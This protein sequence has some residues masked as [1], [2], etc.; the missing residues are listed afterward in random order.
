MVSRRP[1]LLAE[2]GHA[3]RAACRRP[4]P[5]C[6]SRPHEPS[7]R[8]G[9]SRPRSRPRRRK[10]LAGWAETSRIPDVSHA[11][12]ID[13]ALPCHVRRSGVGVAG[14]CCVGELGLGGGRSRTPRGW[15]WLGLGLTL[16][17]RAHT[18]ARVGVCGVAVPDPLPVAWSAGP[19]RGRR[20]RRRRSR[21]RVSSPLRERLRRRRRGRCRR[22]RSPP[23]RGR[24][25]SPRR[26]ARRDGA[27]D[28][29]SG[30]EVI[31]PARGTACGVYGSGMTSILVVEDDDA[32]RS[33][34][35]RGL[36]E[37]GHA[38]AVV[39]TGLAGLE[40]ILRERPQVV[41]LDLGLPDVDGVTLIAMIRAATRRAA[42]RHHRA[43]RRPHDGAR[44]R[45][46]RR[47]LRRQAVRHRPGGGADPRRAAPRAGA[48]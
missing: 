19:A 2:R 7:N 28:S 20:R 5:R 38:V 37:R 30:H 48:T 39:G 43:G 44:P 1:G 15:G 3:C 25:R 40:H 46:R 12:T 17:T 33:A 45:Q 36:R 8:P 24:R 18:R 41:L 6:R 26:P 32:I 4:R 29:W 14:G 34:I 47:R 42:H 23:T 35:A 9:S 11:A 10:P 27:Q 13:P 22:G 31:L 16:G 21:R